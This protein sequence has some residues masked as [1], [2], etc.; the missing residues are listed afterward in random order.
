MSTISQDVRA[1]PKAT[2]SSIIEKLPLTRTHYMLAIAA[3]LG[4][5]FDAFDTYIVG[6][7]MPSIVKEWQLTPVFNGMLASAG[8]WGMFI[9][10]AMLG[11]DH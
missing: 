6:F 11:A 4:Y 5:M 3:A 2:V 1:V 7:A 9:G 8:M 10:A